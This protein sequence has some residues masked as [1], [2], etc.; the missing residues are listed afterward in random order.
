MY[1][2]LGMAKKLDAAL[3]YQL[4][5]FHQLAMGLLFWRALCRFHAHDALVAARLAKLL[6]FAISPARE[7]SICH[8]AIIQVAIYHQEP[9]AKS[10]LYLQC[11]GHCH[12]HQ[13]KT[14]TC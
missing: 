2:A 13:L 12:M 14:Y 11:L 1:N 7:P 6:T 5:T 4:L 8:A 10:L 3:S 9:T